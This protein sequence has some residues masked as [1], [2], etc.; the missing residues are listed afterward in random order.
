MLRSQSIYSAKDLFLLFRK[1]NEAAA[2]KIVKSTTQCA[3]AAEHEITM[4]ERVCLKT[5]LVALVL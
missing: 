5:Y 3:A 1:K 4:L 2:V